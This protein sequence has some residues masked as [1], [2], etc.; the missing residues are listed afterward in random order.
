MESHEIINNYFESY[1]KRGCAW[2]PGKTPG[3]SQP[4]VRQRRLRRKEVGIEE[5]KMALIYTCKIGNEKT[6]FLN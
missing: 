1:S 6:S 3:R 5:T 2:I 4:N